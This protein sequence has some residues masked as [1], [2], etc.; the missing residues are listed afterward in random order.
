MI[1]RKLPYLLSGMDWSIRQKLCSL[2]SNDIIRCNK[3]GQMHHH[4]F[5]F[6]A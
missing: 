3:K 5:V 2:E 1:E 4:T 6:F